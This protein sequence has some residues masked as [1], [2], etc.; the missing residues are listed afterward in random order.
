LFPNAKVHSQRISEHL[1]ALGKL[2]IQPFFNDYLS[3]IYKPEEMSGI[4]I[5]STGVPN[6]IN[7]DLTKINNHNGLI[8]NEI[9]LIYVIDRVKKIPLYFRVVAG[10]IIDVSTLQSTVNEL[11]AHYIRINDALLDAEYYSKDNIKFLFANNINFVTRLISSRLIAKELIGKHF[12]EIINMNNHII[13]NGRLLYVK[14]F[15]ISLFG[16]KA[17]AYVAVDFNRRNDELISLVHNNNNKSIKNRLSNEELEIESQLLGTFVLVSSINLEVHEILPFYSSRNYIEQIF[18]ISK[19]NAI[20]LP[21][22]VHTVEGVMGHILINFLT[23]ISYMKINTYF[24]NTKYSAKNALFEL[25]ML[26]GKLLDSKIYVYEPNKSMKNYF[27]LLNIS[28]PKII[29][30]N[31]N[32]SFNNDYYKL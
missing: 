6:D 25:G 5:D 32:K 2:N 21:L 22:R 24:D 12:N 14:K 4:I 26:I 17:Y 19:N 13:H 27:K 8:S 31:N 18:D 29:N 3:L 7:I 23:V 1:V 11:K 15:E 10:N 9:R 16:H 28:L 30:I 20:L